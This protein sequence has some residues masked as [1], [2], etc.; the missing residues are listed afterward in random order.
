VYNQT[1]LRI[2]VPFGGIGN[3]LEWKIPVELNSGVASLDPNVRLPPLWEL[4]KWV[5]VHKTKRALLT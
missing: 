4:H 2:E 3:D 5:I 1:E